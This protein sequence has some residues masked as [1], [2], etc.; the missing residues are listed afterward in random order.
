MQLTL[1]M[2]AEEHMGFQTLTQRLCYVT[3]GTFAP[4]WSW[5]RLLGTGLKDVLGVLSTGS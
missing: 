4:T 2:A 3:V 5:G 1:V